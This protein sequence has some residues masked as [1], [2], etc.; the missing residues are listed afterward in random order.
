MVVLVLVLI[1]LTH[2]E[3]RDAKLSGRGSEKLR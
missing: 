1:E 3:T 2:S